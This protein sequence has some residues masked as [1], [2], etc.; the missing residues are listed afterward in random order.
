MRGAQEIGAMADM[1]FACERIGEGMFRLQGTKTRLIPEEDK[2]SIDYVVADTEDRARTSVRA[3]EM[4]EVL[5][6][7]NKKKFDRLHQRIIDLL[8]GGPL[9]TNEIATRTRGDRNSILVAIKTLKESGEII[10][11]KRPGRGG[12]NVYSLPLPSSCTSILNADSL[13]ETA[14][15]QA[16]GD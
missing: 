10:S 12:G 16:A 2:I 6:T 8:A 9:T 13:E 7:T 5:A 14:L 1:A 11:T 4:S 15:V 3:V